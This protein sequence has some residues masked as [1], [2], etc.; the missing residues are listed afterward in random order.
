M[1]EER[2]LFTILA[3]LTLGAALFLGCESRQN[4]DRDS[5]ALTQRLG[6]EIPLR[7]NPIQVLRYLDSKGI[8]HSLYIRDAAKGN[9][10]QS[11]I[12]DKSRWDIVREDYSISFQFDDHD[13]L[14]RIDVQSWLTGP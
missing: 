9:S 12:R 14:K 6:A 8:D 10:I 4:D 2:R 5:V 3:V 13:R 7:S 1:S 11:V